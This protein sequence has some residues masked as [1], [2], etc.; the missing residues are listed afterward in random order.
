MET[1]ASRTD[2]LKKEQAMVIEKYRFITSQC[3]LFQL[4]C[5]E[6]EGK[7]GL[8]LFLND[9]EFVVKPIDLV[10]SIYWDEDYCL[11]DSCDKEKE[12][13][14][15]VNI[16]MEDFRYTWTVEHS[17]LPVLWY[18]M[19]AIE[20]YIQKTISAIIEL[21]EATKNSHQLVYEKIDVDEDGIKA[22]LEQLQVK[23]TLPSIVRKRTS[24]ITIESFSFKFLPDNDGEHYTMGIGNREIKTW[25]SHWDGN[26]ELIRHQFETI[27]YDQTAEIHIPFD[28][29][30]T[31]VRLKE[32]SILDEIN[33]DEEFTGFKYKHYMKVEIMPNYYVKRPVIVGYCK[34][35]DT[36][37]N[38]YDGLL[39]TAKDHPE[40]GSHDVPSKKDAYDKVKSPIIEKYLG[41]TK[42]EKQIE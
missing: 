6:V 26:L 40:E 35:K 13:Y 14:Y 20:D 4:S 24:D 1:I 33:E 34:I 7:Y 37:R 15:S 39:S 42:T 16:K 32:L 8:Y 23:G 3:E 28:M 2:Y 29:E 41:S 22:C 5:R 18:K 31:I 21:Y 25:F 11:L 9:K 12:G 17:V 36:V 27:A 30:D 10:N 19:F 38:F